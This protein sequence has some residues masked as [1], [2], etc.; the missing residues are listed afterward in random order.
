MEASADRRTDGELMAM[1]DERSTW[2]VNGRHGKIHYLALTLRAAIVRSVAFDSERPAVMELCRQPSDNVIVS[3]PQLHRLKKL[4]GEP[5][6]E[7]TRISDEV[8]E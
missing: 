4:V 3:A 1:L 7:V 6:E 8:M 2:T 5:E